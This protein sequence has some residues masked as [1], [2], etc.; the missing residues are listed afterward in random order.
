MWSSFI[1][2]ILF[3][4]VQSFLVMEI[5]S[6][7]FFVRENNFSAAETTLLEIFDNNISFYHSSFD[8][9]NKMALPGL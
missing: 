8:T 9:Y 7:C 4:P 3:Y 5:V 1:I 2:Q 6:L